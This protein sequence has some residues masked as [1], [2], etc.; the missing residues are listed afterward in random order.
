L[1]VI[2]II[3]IVTRSQPLTGCQVDEV[4]ETKR[5]FERQQLLLYRS[6]S[7]QAMVHPVLMS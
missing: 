3:I 6:L 7:S 4:K 5:S 1:T 2:T